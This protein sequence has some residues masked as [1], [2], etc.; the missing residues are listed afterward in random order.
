VPVNPLRFRNYKR[1]DILVS[2]SGITV[3]LILALTSAVLFRTIAA[4]GGFY[5]TSLLVG[6]V[7]KLLLYLMNINLI[8]AIFNLI[9]IPPLDGSRVLYHFLPQQAAWQFQKLERYG[10]LLLIVFLYIGVFQGILGV[11]LKLLYLLAGI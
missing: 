6:I 10:F 9:P 11:P 5:P 4:F 7:L 8:L 3:N 2:L 1:D